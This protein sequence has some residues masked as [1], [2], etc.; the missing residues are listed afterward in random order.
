MKN[1]VNFYQ[2]SLK[3]DAESLNLTLVLVCCLLAMIFIAGWS[4]YSS[5]EVDKWQATEK[6]EKRQLE[7]ARLRL[8]HVTDELNAQPDKRLVQQAELLQKQ[9]LAQ[10]YLLKQLDNKQQAG[11]GTYAQL[12]LALASQHQQ[13]IWLTRFSVTGSR[14]QMQGKSL[15]AESVPRWMEKLGKSDYFIGTEFGSLKVFRDE[16]RQLNFILGATELRADNSLR[17]TP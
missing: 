15:N 2:P 7:E 3:P 9:I 1:Q 16:D 14:L 6:T 12:M 11:R 10:K 13:D 17:P 5:A 4:L 8:Q